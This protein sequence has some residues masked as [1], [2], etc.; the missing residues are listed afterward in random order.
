VLQE[1]LTNVLRHSNAT[2]V[3]VRIKEVHD[4]I[5][6]TASDDGQFTEDVPLTPGFGLKGIVE[7]C[8]LHGGTCTFTQEK[9]HGLRI[10]ATIPIEP[11][12]IYYVRK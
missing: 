11:V 1:L 5:V 9:T 10:E 8:R 7:R 12:P 2:T 4:Q 6:L 3:A